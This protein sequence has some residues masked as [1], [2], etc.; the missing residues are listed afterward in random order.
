MTTK[1]KIKIQHL[2]NEYLEVYGSI[3]IQLPDEVSLEIGI[4]QDGVR[5]RR[6]DGNYCWVTTTRDDRTT[7][8]DR[9]AM[10]MKYDNPESKLVDRTEHG[11][12]TVL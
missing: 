12:V 8:L 3:N 10:S 6:R 11:I 7:V 4:T 1:T 2:L 9:Y 5:G